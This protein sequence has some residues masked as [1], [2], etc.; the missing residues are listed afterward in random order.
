MITS[1]SLKEGEANSELS[2]WDTTA[3]ANA[4]KTIAQELLK[5]TVKSVSLV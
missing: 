1:L 4:F 5:G 2:R 3:L